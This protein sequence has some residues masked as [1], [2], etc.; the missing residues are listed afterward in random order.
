MVFLYDHNSQCFLICL[1]LGMTQNNLLFF[2]ASRFGF[3]TNTLDVDNID[4]VSQELI[5]LNKTT[6]KCRT[7][8]C[9]RL[10]K[11]TKISHEN[12]YMAPDTITFY[13]KTY[14][15]NLK[16]DSKDVFCDGPCFPISVWN[17][18]F[19]VIRASQK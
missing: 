3:L 1:R 9:T 19:Y 16:P 11:E 17:V 7:M 6:P 14:G 8:E 13:Q 15:I 2:K 5:V 18:F 4:N 12:L 10:T